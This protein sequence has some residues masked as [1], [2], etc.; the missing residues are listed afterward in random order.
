M[1]MISLRFPSVM[2]NVDANFHYQN[3][4]CD[5]LSH[6]NGSRTW[7]KL[8]FVDLSI[9]PLWHTQNNSKNN[10]LNAN[11]GINS[12]RSSSV[13]VVHVMAMVAA[14]MD[15]PKCSFHLLSH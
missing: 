6:F 11:M 9:K 4:I 1:F 14:F 10:H 13:Y 8:F 2:F 5:F 12:T 7:F 15:L 3:Q